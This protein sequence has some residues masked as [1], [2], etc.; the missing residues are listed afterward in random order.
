MPPIDASALSVARHLVH[1]RRVRLARRGLATIE[2]VMLIALIAVVAAVTADAMSSVSDRTFEHLTSNF[3]PRP[4]PMRSDERAVT[5]TLVAPSPVS[6]ERRFQPRRI[7]P[8]LTL[9]V[10]VSAAALVIGRRRPSPEAREVLSALEKA[11]RT[12]I[13]A[14][15]FVGKRQEILRALSSDLESFLTNHLRVGHL[16]TTRLSTVGPKAR[17][18]EMANVMKQGEL[19]HLLVVD[20][21]GRLLGVVS[22]RDL[23]A[24]DGDVVAAKLMAENPL[25][26]SPSTPLRAAVTMLLDSH[27]SSL[28]VVE[29]D[30]LTGIVTT[31]DIAMALQCAL[32]LV[33][34]VAA[35]LTRDPRIAAALLAAA[36]PS[37]EPSA[38]DVATVSAA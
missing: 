30:R 19:R 26:C 20:D 10:V 7:D 37:A 38:D 4:N 28:P 2:F 29:A 6:P 27:I 12:E 13:G 25:T 31:T 1:G 24:A 21:Q 8:M 22:D 17:A 34:R 18:W 14:A 36:G 3:D 33:E 15:S 5:P 35:D 11:T 32:Q 9:L 16:M 23:K